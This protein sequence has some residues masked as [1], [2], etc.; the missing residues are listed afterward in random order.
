VTIPR[1]GERLETDGGKIGRNG[2][3]IRSSMGYGKPSG[4][5]LQNYGTYHYFVH[6]L[7]QLFPWQFSIAM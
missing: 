1:L 4:K 5:R 7:I 2:V 6:E 3:E